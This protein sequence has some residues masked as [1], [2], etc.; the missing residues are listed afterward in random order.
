VLDIVMLELLD[1]LS[2]VMLDLPLKEVPETPS[3]LIEL[4]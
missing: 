3:L 4:K 2:K 1:L